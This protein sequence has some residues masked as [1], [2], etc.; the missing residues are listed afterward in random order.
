MVGGFYRSAETSATNSLESRVRRRD[1]L[2]GFRFTNSR[3]KLFGITGAATRC[4]A[5]KCPS[6]VAA[7][8]SL[9]SRV[10][11]LITRNSED[12]WVIRHKLFGITGAATR[13]TATSPQTACSPPQ[14]LWN[15]GCGDLPGTASVV[16]VLL[17]RHK[18][19]GITGAATCTRKPPRGHTSSAT[20]SLES[21]VRRHP[22]AW[23]SWRFATPATNSLESRV[24]RLRALAT[25]IYQ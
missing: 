11:R 12:A 19:F 14:T 18:L 16:V 13:S 5:R 10:R 24:R 6:T 2:E 15:H 8:N 22:G 7:T 23:Q 9:E 3:H 21:R 25:Y 20:N 4:R 17:F 1:E